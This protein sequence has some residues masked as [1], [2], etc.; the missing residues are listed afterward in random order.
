MVSDRNVVVDSFRSNSANELL[1]EEV[2]LVEFEMIIL[3]FQ[4]ISLL[5][6]G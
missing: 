4:S 3:F 1:Q 5:G 6:D 2:E